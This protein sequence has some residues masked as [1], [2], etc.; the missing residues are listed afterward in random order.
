MVSQF[1]QSEELNC[2]IIV[3]FS[4]YKV[5]IMD[6]TNKKKR[7]NYDE[8]NKQ[9][10]DNCN[11][12]TINLKKPKLS[13][14][15][16][17]HHD[18]LRTVQKPYRF[19]IPGGAI[20][21]RCGSVTKLVELNHVKLTTDVSHQSKKAPIDIEKCKQKSSLPSDQDKNND[22]NTLKCAG[23]PKATESN[24]NVAKMPPKSSSMQESVAHKPAPT[25]SDLIPTGDIGDVL[26]AVPKQK[27]RHIK[28]TQVLHQ[29]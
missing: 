11:P 16:K 26:N 9:S 27:K 18:P 6:E 7:N 4:G 5:D 22:P 21:E 20:F 29:E 15:K 13:K 25:A 2:A 14:H 17:M 12:N 19:G 8:T 23:A 28:Q 10:D 24:I 1:R 3:L